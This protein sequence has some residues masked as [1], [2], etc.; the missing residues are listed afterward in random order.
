MISDN[1]KTETRIGMSLEDYMRE[2]NE[3][4]F[5]M[6]NGKQI[7][8]IPNFALHGWI[9]KEVFRCV[10]SFAVQN[11]L[12]EAFSGMTY[13]IHEQDNMNW[14]TGSRDPDM[15]FFERNRIDEY[16]RDHPDWQSTPMLIV[17][18]LAIEILSP[19]DT[20]SLMDEK[21]SYDLANGV[22][23]VWLIDP[24][25][26]KAWVY[27]PDGDSPVVF[28]ADGILVEETLLP[29]FKLELAKIWA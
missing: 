26:R 28:G 3:K 4:P 6:I 24:N 15:A 10:D 23:A 12:G 27:T 5:E 17:P 19:N 13:A 1:P 11:Q 21:V 22:K 7:Y 25:R 2:A 16:F 9:L 20:F 8:R 29:N 14:I 18:D